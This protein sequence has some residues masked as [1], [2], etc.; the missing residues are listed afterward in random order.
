MFFQ[1]CS[2]LESEV[3]NASNDFKVSGLGQRVRAALRRN[4]S[5]GDQTVLPE[6]LSIDAPGPDLI[7][8]LNALHLISLTDSPLE[9]QPG[10]GDR[11]LIRALTESVQQV[12]QVV[13]YFWSGSLQE[14]APVFA[15]DDC[16][17]HP[18]S[19][20]YPESRALVGT[21]E[22]DL[23]KQ[24]ASVIDK[25][26]R[27]IV[28]TSIW[29]EAARYANNLDGDKLDELRAAKLE[30]QENVSPLGGETIGQ[31]GDRLQSALESAKKDVPT[32][33]LAANRLVWATVDALISLATWGREFEREDISDISQLDF[34]PDL[35]KGFKVRIARIERV[36]PLMS[37]ESSFRLNDEGMLAGIATT[38]GINLH[39]DKNSGTNIDLNVVRLSAYES[40][41]IVGAAS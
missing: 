10:P 15:D 12:R 26:K 7:R 36:L 9:G 39:G 5:A 19:P 8:H 24:L 17:P 14:I 22:F 6:Y 29:A 38:K 25:L 11:E 41:R 2:T 32:E 18:F 16:L 34:G 35:P 23:P 28:Q 21:D 27:Q 31:W 30:N 40:R 13:A 3:A 1:D 37:L 33:F 20:T 4:R